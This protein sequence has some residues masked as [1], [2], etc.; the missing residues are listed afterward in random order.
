MD[1]STIMLRCSGKIRLLFFLISELLFRKQA[2][3]DAGADATAL[4]CLNSN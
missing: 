4:S 1:L 2:A 3:K